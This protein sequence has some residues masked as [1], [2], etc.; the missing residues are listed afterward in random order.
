M[1]KFLLSLL[2]ALLI[3]CLMFTACTG[4]ET[5]VSNGDSTSNVQSTE[6]EAPVQSAD[7]SSVDVSSEDNSVAPLTGLWKDATVT[8]D[9]TYGE[10]AVTI[11]VE[12]KAEDKSVTLTIKTDKETLGDALTEHNLVDG[13]KSEYGLYVKKVIGMTADYDI[14]QSYWSFSK[15]GEMMM[16]GVDGENISDGAHYEITYTK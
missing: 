14:D 16:T 13:E 5:D 1:K 12:V 15:D 7:A 11:Q 2:S 9:T 8:E 10:G 3:A 6:S 4:S